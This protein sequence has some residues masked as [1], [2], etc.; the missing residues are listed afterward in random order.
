MSLKTG[1]IFI[2]IY[3]IFFHI[4]ISKYFYTALFVP[5]ETDT[6]IVNLLCKALLNDPAAVDTRQGWLLL[7]V[8]AAGGS[9]AAGL[10]VM[11]VA[12]RLKS[13][14][15]HMPP[16]YLPPAIPV[17]AA[18]LGGL[19]FPASSPIQGSLISLNFQ[20]SCVLKF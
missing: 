5:I 15:S 19:P 16:R 14:S 10:R 11:L 1:C 17:D 6:C 12:V 4:Q 13:P 2:R 18:R 3:Y 20:P 7:S 9:H 8:R